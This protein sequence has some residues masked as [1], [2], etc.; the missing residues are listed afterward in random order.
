M[1]CVTVAAFFLAVTL[2]AQVVVIL[3]LLG[4][5]LTPILLSTGEDR[6]ARA[7]WIHR[8]AECG[9]RGRRAAKALGLSR[10]FFRPSARFSWNP[11]GRRSF[12]DVS[13]ET[14]TFVVCLGFEL[15]FLADIFSSSKNAASG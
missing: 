14:V 8:I 11:C 1:S 12:F 5:F 9:C 7:F 3:G 13:K 2:D 15:L 10:C 6:P 4:G